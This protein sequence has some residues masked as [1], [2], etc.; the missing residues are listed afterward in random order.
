MRCAIREEDTVQAELTIIRSITKISAIRPVRFAIIT[1]PADTL[2]DKIP[3]KATLQTRILS[4]C[5]PVTGKSAKAIVHRMGI[6][7]EDQGT[8]FARHADPFLDCPFRYRRERLILIDASIHRTNNIGGS[9]IRT[10]TFILYWSAWIAGFH[11]AVHTV[12]HSTMPG[13]IAQRPDDDRW[14][15]KITLY[16]AGNSF[17]ESAGPD[18]I[19]R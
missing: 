17:S 14:V 7:T 18:R 15:V 9:R 10:A 16:H 3:D 5:I 13:F 4:E 1:D 8:I 6:F 11:P 12:L 19:I 2:V